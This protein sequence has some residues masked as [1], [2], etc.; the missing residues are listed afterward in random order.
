MNDKKDWKLVFRAEDEFEA[1]V[2]K[3]KLQ[4]KGLEAMLFNRSDS[5]FTVLDDSQYSAGVLVHPD[6]EQK[7]LEIIANGKKA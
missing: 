1:E 7:A 3:A 6:D 5:M 4:E 2:I